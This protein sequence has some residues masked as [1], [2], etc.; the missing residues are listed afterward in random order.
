MD[1]ITN[2][3]WILPTES[4]VDCDDL[5][6][7]GLYLIFIGYLVPLLSPRLRNY[8]RE[9]ISSIKNVGKITGNIVSLTEYGFEKVQGLSTNAEMVSFIERLCEINDLAVLPTQLIELSWEFS[10]DTDY[11]KKVHMLQTWSKLRSELER[12]N[13]LNKLDKTTKP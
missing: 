3:S 11:G 7:N 10:G 4:L 8:G 2:T 9:L 13:M 5:T 1:N 6:N 12:Y